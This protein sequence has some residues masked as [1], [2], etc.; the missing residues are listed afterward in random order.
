M[1]ERDAERDGW[2]PHRRRYV[3]VHEMRGS[4]CPVDWCPYGG[5]ERC[6]LP[7]WPAVGDGEPAADASAEEAVLM[8]ET[9]LY[10]MVCGAECV[11]KHTKFNAFWRLLQ[12]VTR[13]TRSMLDDER[14]FVEM[15]WGLIESSYFVCTSVPSMMRYGA[16]FPQRLFAL[17]RGAK[18]GVPRRGEV[19]TAV[20]ATGVRT[21]FEEE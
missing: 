13:D 9:W 7:H 6:D 21:L 12:T 16:A 18:G 4:A 1:D 15:I 5:P 8:I 10:C 14:E 11:R 19:W 3:L 17:W 20:V 2:S